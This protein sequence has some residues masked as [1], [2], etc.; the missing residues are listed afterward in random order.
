M[1]IDPSPVS[2]NCSS[3][4]CYYQNVRGLCTKLKD[5]YLAC[6]LD[7]NYKVIALSEIWLHKGIYDAELFNLALFNVFRKDRGYLATGRKRSGGILLLL[8]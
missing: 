7:S 3:V 5:F 4:L 1:P 8:R 6:A 2:D